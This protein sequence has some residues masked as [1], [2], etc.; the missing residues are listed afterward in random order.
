MDIR[1]GTSQSGRDSQRFHRRERRSA[2][3]DRAWGRFRGTTRSIVEAGRRDEGRRIGPAELRLD[4]VE[5]DQW[6]ELSIVRLTALEEAPDAFIAVPDQEQSWQETDWRQAIKSARW[7]AARSA[8]AIIGLARSTTDGVPTRRHI[9]AVWVEPSWRRRRVA[10]SLV[11]WL[12]EKER[13]TDV[14]QEILVW[15]I[16]S[17]KAARRLYEGLGFEPTGEPPQPI[18]GRGSRVEERLR[19]LVADG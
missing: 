11:R 16:D 12:I 3:C 15:V 5:V 4:E 7:V 9:E 17:N 2:P 14:V 10:S 6:Q 18:K 13:E 19:L 1:P 8:D